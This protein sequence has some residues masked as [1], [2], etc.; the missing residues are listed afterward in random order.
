M[1]F[2]SN[3]NVWK[4]LK[5]SERQFKINHKKIIIRS[6]KA[7]FVFDWFD[8]MNNMIS[9]VEIWRKKK[10]EI[11]IYKTVWMHTLSCIICLC[12]HLFLSITL[13]CCENFS[14]NFIHFSDII[15]SIADDAIFIAFSFTSIC[16]LIKLQ[17]T[18]FFE[19][20]THDH[21]LRWCLYA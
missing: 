9:V 18:S 11:K 3:L 8:A 21:L 2:S 1:D 20:A 14:Y 5:I 7:C 4:S 16:P 17:N 12:Y 15:I 13:I 6:V 19:L 10:E